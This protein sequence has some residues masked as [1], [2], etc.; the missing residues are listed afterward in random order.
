[1]IGKQRYDI[2]FVAEHA[3]DEALEGLLWA[4]FDEYANACVVQLVQPFNKLH[5]R[6]DLLA[7]TVDDLVHGAFT[8]LVESARHVADNREFGFANLHAG[9]H[10][11]QWGAGGSNDAGMEC[12]AYRKRHCLHTFRAEALDRFVDGG[13]IAA[14]DS[15]LIAIDVSDDKI[16]IDAG[17]HALDVFQWREHSSHLAV[18]FHGDVGHFPATRAH[19]LER[20]CEGQNT[21]LHER[22]VLTKAVAHD[23]VGLHAIL[24]EQFRQRGIGSQHCRLRD[25]GLPERVISFGQ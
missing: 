11:F 23:H 5:W 16:A 12:M 3:V 2:A 14:D 6:R 15:L 20:L 9:E 17:Q 13:T 8:G 22:R 7:K 10:C 21:C 25:L 24:A 18:V 1:M 4:N 19:G